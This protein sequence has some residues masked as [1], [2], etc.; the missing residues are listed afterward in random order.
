MS[1][2]NIQ[3]VKSSETFAVVLDD[4]AT[5]G[6]LIEG[7]LGV[8]V[9]LFSSMS[10]LKE[11]CEQL[12]PMGVFVD[13]HLTDG[14]SGLEIVPLIK[15]RWPSCPIIVITGDQAESMVGE[16]LAMGAD[17]FI[18]KPVRPAELRARYLARKSEIDLRNKQTI[19]H[20]G[21][22]TLNLLFKSLNGPKGE[23][24]QSPREVEIL[25]YLIRANG[26]IVDKNSLKR[27]I[28]GNISVSDNALDRKLFEVRKAIKNV[29][30]TVEIHAIY[31]HGVE[32]RV[33]PSAAEMNNRSFRS[34]QRPQL[35]E[36]QG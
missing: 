14:E 9:V 31:N 21:D 25:A 20:F 3:D 26:M 11:Q 36:A 1:N 29:S 6:R 18:R 17:D 23:Y 33:K 30:D 10:E 8:K 22:I 32:L 24:F 5:M 27:R 35:V 15:A 19:L 34:G 7:I 4:D 16:A 12:S 13:I 28:W 2:E